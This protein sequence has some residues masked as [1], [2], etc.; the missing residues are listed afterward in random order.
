MPRKHD[1]LKIH[2]RYFYTTRYRQQ[3]TLAI[4]SVLVALS[5]TNNNLAPRNV[6]K[7]CHKVLLISYRTMTKKIKCP[8]IWHY[9]SCLG[10]VQSKQ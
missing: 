7:Q 2:E 8:K 4:Y 3:L 10:C 1:I 9:L 6:L 5:I